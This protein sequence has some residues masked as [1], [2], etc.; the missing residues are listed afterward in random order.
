MIKHF[1][2]KIIVNFLLTCIMC[3]IFIERPIWIIKIETVASFCAY[4]ADYRWNFRNNWR[5]ITKTFDL[6]EFLFVRSALLT[7]KDE[8]N[9][10]LLNKQAQK[11]K[12]VVLSVI[13]ITIFESFDNSLALKGRT[14][15]A[16][17]TDDI[18]FSLSTSNG[19]KI[20]AS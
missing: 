5:L 20:W 18:F 17:F 2:T 1:Y 13:A 10:C 8:S 16:T 4:S 12:L 14:R 3:I 15:T 19:L 6:R 9:S 7:Q 11:S